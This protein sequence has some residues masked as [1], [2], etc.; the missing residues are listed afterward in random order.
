VSDIPFRVVG[1][2]VR[3]S[4][5]DESDPDAARIPGQWGRVLG[6]AD[7]MALPGRIGDEVFAVL[8]DYDSDERGPYS[9]LVGV[10]AAPDTA[11]ARW[12]SVDVPDIPRRRYEVAGEMPLAL[13]SAWQQIWSDSADGSLRRSFTVDVE[14]HRADGTAAILVATEPD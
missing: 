12:D 11:D 8:F 6:D 1:H 5:A 10:R 13:I 3:T 14:E 4:N 9:Q 7:L 2:L